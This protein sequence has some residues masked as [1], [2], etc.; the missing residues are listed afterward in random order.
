VIA[1][2][3]KAEEQSE[4][5]HNEEVQKFYKAGIVNMQRQG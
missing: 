5:D 2:D 3:P 4:G 1:E